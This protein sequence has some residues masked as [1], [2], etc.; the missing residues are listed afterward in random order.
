MSQEAEHEKRRAQLESELQWMA[1]ERKRDH[2]R[3]AAGIVVSL[4]IAIPMMA[5][6]A[7]VTDEDLGR[8]WLYSGLLIGDLGVLGSA[9]WGLKRAVDR[10]D[11]QW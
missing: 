9:V 5:M 11:A 8:G 1:R 2:V 7:H 4:L 6:S 3:M 10:G